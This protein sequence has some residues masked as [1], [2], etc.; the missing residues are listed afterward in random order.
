VS[1]RGPLEPE[2]L[3]L[4]ADE[5]DGVDAAAEPLRQ[6]GDSPGTTPMARSPLPAPVIE[7]A[8][9]HIPAF[10]PF[11]GPLVLRIIVPSSQPAAPLLV[12]PKLITPSS[13]S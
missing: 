1:R 3:R 7:S 9:R 10:M 4:P 8:K 5:Q 11:A 12:V 2:E 6:L 13:A